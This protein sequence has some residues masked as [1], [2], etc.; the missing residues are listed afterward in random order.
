MKENDEVEKKEN[1]TRR[2]KK[3]EFVPVFHSEGRDGSQ[4][5]IG[6]DEKKG[7]IPTLSVYVKD[8]SLLD[9]KSIDN[10]IQEIRKYQ[11]KASKDDKKRKKE[12]KENPKPEKDDQLKKLGKQ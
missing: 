1:I 3:E 10:L 12:A 4:I 9:N 7:G 8:L 11:I 5:V 6:F 2:K